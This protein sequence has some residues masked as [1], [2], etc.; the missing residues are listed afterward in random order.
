MQNS[1]FGT[2]FS[3]I[4]IEILSFSYK[5]MHLKMSSAKMAAILSRGRRVN[6]VQG[7]HFRNVFF[8]AYGRVQ[9]S[10]WYENVVCSFNSLSPWRCG[11]NLEGIIFKLITQNS[12]FGT[13]YEIALR[14]MPQHLTNNKSTLVQAT[15]WCHQVTSYYWANIDTDLCPHMVL[16]S[17]NGLIHV[18]FLSSHEM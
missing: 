13:R 4:W 6:G 3:E 9:G 15:A 7:H 1:G 17:H 16:W 2:S 12:G 10:E 18:V 14:W 8:P 5:K 11:N